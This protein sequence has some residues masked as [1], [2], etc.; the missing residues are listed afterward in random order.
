MEDLGLWGYNA[1]GV[2]YDMRYAG[3][4]FDDPIGVKF[5]ARLHAIGE[6]AK[7]IGMDFALFVI[8]NESYQNSPAAL[9]ADAGG[10]RGSIYPWNVCPSKP[11]GMKYILKVLGEEF[12]WAADLQPR[13]LV[14]WPYDAGGCGCAACRPWGSNGFLKATEAVAA[15]ARQKLP[16]TKIVL[17]TWMF[18]EGEWQGLNKVF[19]AKQPWADYILA[20]GT[21][22]PMPGKLP[23]VGFPEISMYETFPWGGFGATP[24][25]RRAEQQWNAVKQHSSGGFPYSEG[26]F[27]DITKAVLG[28]LY[29]NDRPAAETLR[30]Y[31]A[32]EYSP[33]A[34]DEIVKI[35]ATLE[36]NHHMA[37]VARR[38]GGREAGTRLVPLARRGP[39]GRPGR[40][41]GLCRR[42][43]HRRE[44]D[45]AGPPIVALAAALPA[46]V[47]GCRVEDQRRQAQRSL[48]G[49]LCRIDQDLSRGERQPGPSPAAAPKRSTAMTK[50]DKMWT[51]LAIAASVFFSNAV[52]F[53]DDGRTS[54]SLNGTSFTVDA[55]VRRSLQVELPGQEH[56][57]V[58]T[59][60]PGIGCWFWTAEE[61]QPE[62]YKRFL[63]L[64]AKHSA[65]RLL[66]TSIRHP[67]EVTD[68]KVHDQIKAAAEYARKH[69]MAIVMDLDVR[70]ARRAFQDRY[71]DEL[72]EIVR[73]REVALTEAGEASLAIEP[74]NLGDHYTY[75]ARGYDSVSARLLRVYSYVAGTQGDRAGY[76]PGHHR[77]LEGGAGRREGRAGGDSLHG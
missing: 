40:G 47:V 53:G 46:G 66:T 58:K 17:S 4:G 26:L 41:G 57:A 38:V 65:F 20:E 63:D 36:Q 62:G 32:F 28:Q 74:I 42:A 54:I 33:D 69:D 9:R 8:A 39:A 18:D 75:R 27:E 15:S 68:P 71:P 10:M 23:M 61:F 5:R 19:A 67:V 35:V 1:L 44:A 56:N 14:L 12:D 59:S 45:P 30:E 48:Q 70:L 37:V 34:V 31:A 16:G 6:S 7:R 11:E 72:Q 51:V 24:L 49:G 21:T 76:R 52:V 25:S 55:A 64:H 60:W 50:T 77:P 2:W 73:L 13:Y 29:W 43:G 22:R 3:K